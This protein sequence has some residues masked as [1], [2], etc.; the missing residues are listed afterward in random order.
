MPD[1]AWTGAELNDGNGA[2]D[3]EPWNPPEIGPE[4]NDGAGNPPVEPDCATTGAATKP[5]A[6]KHA[7]RHT[8]D[9]KDFL[10]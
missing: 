4:L 3:P 7:V 6:T 5:N 10:F 1:P 2:A 8:L 9:S